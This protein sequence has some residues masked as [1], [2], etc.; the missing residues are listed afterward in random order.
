M[1]GIRFGII[2]VCC[3]VLL[4]SVIPGTTQP[5]VAAL[6]S[7]SCSAL[8]QSALEAAQQSCG[9]T[10][11]NSVCWG[12]DSLQAN[13]VDSASA[14]SFKTSGDKIDLASLTSVSASAANLSAK[15]WGVAVLNIQAGLTDGISAVLFG[16]ATITSTVQILSADQVTLP[17]KSFTGGPVLLRGGGGPNYQA[18]ITLKGDQTAMADG[19]TKAGDWIRIR[20]ENAVGWA[21]V[22]Q[23]EVTGDVNT[24]PVL[25]PQNTRADFLYQAPMQAFTLKTASAID[26]A[27][28]GAAPSGL[29]LQRS[30]ED[31]ARL[32]VNG[33]DLTFD[34]ATIM[35]RATPKDRLEI[36]VLTGNATVAALGSILPLKAGEWVRLYIG[37]TDGLIVSAPPASKSSYTFAVVDG[38]PVNLLTQPI[39][40]TVG[41][42]TGSKT[43]TNEQAVRVGPGKERGSLFYLRPEQNFKVIG[44]AKDT[45]GA[46]WWK[47]E[48]ATNPQAWIAKSAVHSLGACDQIEAAAAPP[49][50]VAMSSGE[51]TSGGDTTS[52]EPV[53]QGFAPTAKT[54][55][56]ADP[57]QDQLT[58]TCS[59]IVLNY[60]AQL[61]ALTPKGNGFLWKG[62]ELTPY[63]LVRIRENVYAYSGPN[64]LGDG[65]IKLTL[66]FTSPTSFKATHIVTTYDQPSCQHNYTFTGVFLR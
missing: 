19:R 24:L 26:K 49:V 10:S 37:G 34:D 45:A 17:V 15:Q 51:D 42:P 25:E 28:C 13:F 43:G 62:Q 57:G 39:N 1:R 30:A 29:L 12:F 4:A 7:D 66:A 58:G 56:N 46:D 59:G 21:Y 22:R 64:A 27:A 55:W 8:A 41:L 36:A 6:Q 11:A 52:S 61:V 23:I 50:I 14:P 48:I 60:C 20:S 3:F 18:A 63:S 47:L 35:V 65:T 54:I 38:A 44:Q 5:A 33:A 40:C 16:D 9:T 31:T 2:A 53:S 32:S